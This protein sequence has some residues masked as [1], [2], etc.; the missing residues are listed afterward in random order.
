M[1][2]VSV[3]PIDSPKLTMIICV[4][5]PKITFISLSPLF[6]EKILVAPMAGDC[7]RTQKQTSFCVLPKPE[8]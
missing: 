1:M 4:A 6:M 8:P 7:F 3:I 2:K 5:V